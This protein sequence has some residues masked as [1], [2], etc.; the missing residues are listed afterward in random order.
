M[1][2]TLK[3]LLSIVIVVSLGFVSGYST[4]DA[5]QGWYTT[6]NKPFFQPPNWLFAPV[7]TVLYIMIGLSFGLIITKVNDSNAKQLA[8]KVFVIQLFL[9]L[10]WSP[11]FFSLQKPLFAAMVI[12]VLAILIILTIKMFQR[13]YQPAGQLLIPYLIW[14]VFATCLNIAIVVLN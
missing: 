3:I 11:I 4:A 8:I 5:I 13:L 1:S 9:N 2:D 10:I 14:V 6:I 7:W 12:I